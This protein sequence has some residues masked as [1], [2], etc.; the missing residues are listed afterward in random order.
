MAVSIIDFGADPSGNTD[1]TQAI[2][3]ALNSGSSHVIAPEGTY[4]IR[5]I[6]F[7]AWGFS[8]HPMKPYIFDASAATFVH[9]SSSSDFAMVNIYPGQNNQLIRCMFKFGFILGSPN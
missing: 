7:S 4:K 8:A 2:L 6:D 3:N 5:S 1:S 9:D